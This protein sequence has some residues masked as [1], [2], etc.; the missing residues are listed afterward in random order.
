MQGAYVGF[1]IQQC[2]KTHGFAEQDTYWRHQSDAAFGVVDIY[3]PSDSYFLYYDSLYNIQWLHGFD[4]FLC[5]C[6]LTHF[7]LI[8][9]VYTQDIL[10]I[11]T[12]SCPLRLYW[13]CQAM[14][15][16]LFWSGQ[17]L[18][19]WPFGLANRWPLCRLPIASRS[20]LWT[21]YFY[22]IW[23]SSG[24]CWLLCWHEQVLHWIPKAISHFCFLFLVFC[25]CILI[26]AKAE[27]SIVC[28][29][30]V[31]S[32]LQR[33]HFFGYTI[34]QRALGNQIGKQL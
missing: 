27:T 6:F 22:A 29:C 17:L 32:G 24:Q 2:I 4:G 7:E 11:Y 12:P 23:G 31:P 5:F 18:T 15:R 26:K 1:P 13:E 25:S 10:V 21:M 3:G 30:H 20:V 34:V 8:Y 28:I 9:V 33:F 16:M 19:F 14:A